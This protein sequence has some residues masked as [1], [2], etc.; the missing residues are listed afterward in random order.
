MERARAGDLDTAAEYFRL[1]SDRGHALAAY[2][3]ASLHKDRGQL[4]DAETHYRRALACDLPPDERQLVADCETSLGFI[5]AQAGDDVEAERLYRAADAR[6]NFEATFNLGNLLS[7]T[8]RILE[9]EDAWRRAAAADQPDA[10][11]NLAELVAERGDLQEAER[12]LRQALAAGITDALNNLAQVRLRR[13]DPAEAETLLRQAV[14]AGDHNAVFN[15]GIVLDVRGKREEAEATLRRAAAAGH[16]EAP[17]YIER[18][19]AARAAQ[20]PA[21]QDVAVQSQPVPEG[22]NVDTGWLGGL[23]VLFAEESSNADRMRAAREFVA[24][25]WARLQTATNIA[26]QG[27]DMLAERS[28]QLVSEVAT[29]LP[30]RTIE[31]LRQHAG[32][33]P[34]AQSRHVI[35]GAG[36]LAG[37][38]WAVAAA[39]PGPPP[40]VQAVKVI[41]HSAIEVRM[42]GE[43]YAIHSEAGRDAAWLGT[44]LLAWAS[45]R[46]VAPGHSVAANTSVLVGKIRS[47]A[48]RVGQRREPAGDAG[49]SRSRW[50]KHNGTQ[51]KSDTSPDAAAFVVMGASRRP[52]DR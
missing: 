26:G 51:R 46:P 42:I 16:A 22:S 7:R 21:R 25:A 14:A 11:Y 8:G 52:V 9:A 1:A 47:C 32:D 17:A 2:A 12:L 41:V 38:L 34:E 24:N 19:V 6:G 40:V 5:R 28:A 18:L 44:V 27:R 3:L 37:V 29:R 4:A 49:K 31:N 36:R 20:A 30:I 23:G 10:A 45:G 43:L 15:L 33:D 39:A 13:G 50:R 35:D 48:N